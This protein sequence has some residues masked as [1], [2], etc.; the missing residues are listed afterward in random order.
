[1]KRKAELQ[2]GVYNFLGKQK[3][4][5]A[6]IKWKSSKKHPVAF[7]AYIT[8]EEMDIL[9]QKNIYG[10]LKGK[11]NKGPF[12][13]PSLQGSGSGSEGAGT[14]DGPGTGA[15]EGT[16][17]APGPNEG[18]EA[19]QAAANAAEVSGVAGLG[20][21]DTFGSDVDP[22]NV[23]ASQT[24]EE[25]EEESMGSKAINKVMA[26][27]QSLPKIA[28]FAI[29]PTMTIARDLM[30]PATPEQIAAQQELQ[31]R[32]EI[33]DGAPQ[34]DLNPSLRQKKKKTFLTGGIV[35]L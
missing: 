26:T 24:A 18:A 23:M 29:S 32:A 1:M 2:G 7:L 10:S 27:F 14:G 13:L 20:Q 12:G 30:N 31:D 33:A 17:Q 35:N 15:A 34:E 25:D 28:Q 21:Q 11:P 16:A 5:N 22:E 3:T 19:A 8:K 6:P 4:V 9:I